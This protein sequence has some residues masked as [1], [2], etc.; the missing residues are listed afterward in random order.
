MPISPEV[1]LEAS[2]LLGR[3]S[4]YEAGPADAI[5]GVRPRVVVE[6]DSPEAVA[7]VLAWASR[8]RLAVVL[9]GNGTKLGWGRRPS[10]IDLIVT[11]RRLNQV[12]AHQH[13]DLTATVQAGAT[14]RT[15]N[16]ELAQRGQWL[17][18]DVTFNDATVGGTIA[19]NDSGPLSH[20]H[21]T[22]RDLLIGVRLAM[23]DGRVVKAGG[24]VVKNV[25]GY[26]LGKL[27]SGSFGTLAAIVSATFKL[28]PLPASS[29]TLVAS[30]GEPEELARAVA[31][32]A[33]S[34]LGPVALDVHVTVGR[35][36][37]GLAGVNG[38]ASSYEL[39]VQFASTREVVDLQIDDVARLLAADRSEVARDADEADRWREHRERESMQPGAVIK[40]SWLPASLLS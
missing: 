1:L 8:E 20:R 14:V 24:N 35:G 18:I 38:A 40:M 31:A 29:A 17:P 26:D 21:G 15:L 10:N 39:L 6:P 37:A 5:D 36:S 27:M 22:P 23:T 12:T 4:A 9:R 2:G 13:G 32:A 25:A 34:Q 19:V 30:Y 3:A 11:T 7:S 33:S 28:A 16:Q